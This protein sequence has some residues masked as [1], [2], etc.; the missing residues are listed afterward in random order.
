M[1]GRLQR[2]IYRIAA[3]F[4][5]VCLTPSVYAGSYIF[6]G[7]MNGIDVI[8]HPTGYTG[9]GGVLNVSV[10]ID[11]ASPNAEDMVASVRNAVDTFNKDQAITN[12][13]FFSS[14]T[15]IPASHVDFES[16]VLHEIG[17]CIGLAHVNAATESGLPA[18][19]RNYT[20]A[21]DGADNTFNIGAGA[22][23]V[24]GT[25]DD[26][27]GDDV[28]LH[29]FNTA[30]NDPCSLYGGLVDS[31]TFSREL[32]DLP[33]G[34]K[35]AANADRDVCA[36]L[37]V[38]NT[39]AVMQQGAFSNEDQR[40]LTQAGVSTLALAKSGLDEIAGTAD[41]YS[42]QLNFIGLVANPSCDINVSFDD[43]ETGFAVCKTGGSFINSTHLAITSANVFFNTGFNW[44]FNDDI[45][46]FAP[47]TTGAN[48]AINMET[49]TGGQR[50]RASNTIVSDDHVIQSGACVNYSAANQI[51]IGPGFSVKTGG[52]FRAEVE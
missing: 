3:Y 5:A 36:A 8:T 50:Y 16:T 38:E 52:I 31:L 12:N 29:W 10:C 47:K 20:K 28:N 39:E 22:D 33:A 17:H 26:V 42:I 24:I 49:T 15:N 34:D 13:L 30:D 2:R 32:A 51:G 19:D 14:E 25:F 27:R 1:K 18:A 40:A 23:T 37:D 21:T 4:F 9:V 43:T 11:S 41:D 46:S 6:A 44:Y 35:F 48:V 7:E 45:C